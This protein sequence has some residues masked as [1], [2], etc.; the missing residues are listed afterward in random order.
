MLYH[1]QMIEHIEANFPLKVVVRD[2]NDYL[3][4]RFATMDYDGDGTIT[5]VPQ[6]QLETDE[7]E[8]IYFARKV[9]HEA[10]HWLVAL[11]HARKM[12]NYGLNDVKK[13]AGEPTT[14]VVVADREVELLR[15]VFGEDHPVTKDLPTEPYR[16]LVLKN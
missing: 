3:H 15:E 13:Y 11:P 4:V 8:A 1:Q 14:E 16:Q 12:V 5:V 10:A 9:A 6:G 7:E 2:V